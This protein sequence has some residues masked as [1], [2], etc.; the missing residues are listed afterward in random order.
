MIYPQNS[1]YLVFTVQQEVLKVGDPRSRQPDAR[2]RDPSLQWLHR[3]HSYCCP[4]PA[5][6]RSCRT[7]QATQH[8]CPA[9]EHREHGRHIKERN[10]SSAI[11]VGLRYK[12][13]CKITKSSEKYSRAYPRQRTS[14]PGFTTASLSAASVRGVVWVTSLRRSDFTWTVTLASTSSWPWL[15][16]LTTNDSWY[17]LAR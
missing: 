16:S 10:S 17:L 6:P 11:N 9:L 1:S 14:T 8:R 5:C 7:H 2:G 13:T 4:A 3:Q 12:E 15:L